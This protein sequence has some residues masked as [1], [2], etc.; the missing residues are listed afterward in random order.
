MEGF[1]VSFVRHIPGF[2]A[3][4][5]LGLLSIPSHQLL[6]Q[7]A[8]GPVNQNDLLEAQQNDA[9]WL[10]YGRTYDSKRYSALKQINRQNVDKLI[11]AWYEKYQPNYPEIVGQM[12]E[13]SVKPRP[14]QVFKLARL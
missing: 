11:S 7:E 1:A 12:R 10:M 14:Y 6:S 13:V 9:S 8:V 2:S 4:I 5:V 3:L